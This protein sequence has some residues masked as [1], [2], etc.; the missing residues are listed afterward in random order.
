MADRPHGRP[1]VGK[2]HLYAHGVPAWFVFVIGEDQILST[3]PIYAVDLAGAL[4][5]YRQ[6]R[7][8][9]LPTGCELR[10]T[11]GHLPARQDF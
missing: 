10:Q 9:D 1:R 11:G 6:R 8:T 4:E 3:S 7:G 5:V 2:P